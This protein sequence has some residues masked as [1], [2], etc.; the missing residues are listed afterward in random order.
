[1][2]F[3]VFKTRYFKDE[4]AF[5]LRNKNTPLMNELKYKNIVLK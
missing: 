4:K 5:I 2:N 3:I 1:M